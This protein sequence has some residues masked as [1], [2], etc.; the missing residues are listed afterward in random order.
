MSDL[1]AVLAAAEPAEPRTLD[2]LVDRLT[3]RRLV[4]GA[5]AADRRAIDPRGLGGLSIRGISQDSRTVPRDGLFVAIPGAHVDG[6]DRAGEAADRGALCAVVEHALDLDLPQLVVD[7]SRRALAEAAAWWYAD[8]SRELVVVG[9]T[10]TDGKTTTSFL[11]AAVLEAAG[12]RPGLVGTV[13]IGVG[14]QRWPN[15][16]HVTTP[17]APELQRMLRAM[18]SAGDRSAVVESTS[19]GLAL[20]RLD[21]VAYDAAILTNVT[22]EHLELHGTWE[23]YRDAKLSLFERLAPGA[24]NP[25]KDAPKVAIVNAD[26]PSAG[27]FAGVAQ[28][29]GARVVTYGTD[30]QADVR[31]TRVEEDRSGLA[32]DYRSPAGGG[33]VRVR[34]AGRFNA[35]N[36]LAV[37][38]LGEAWGLDAEA[39]RS[40]IESVT[41]VPG[42][43]ERID[44]G[45]PFQVVVDYAHSPAS[46]A[47]V[48]DLLA[49]L[50]A[51]QGGGLV[52][53]FG[54]AGERDVDKRSAM[55]RIAGERC[56]LVVVTDED[57]RGEDREAILEAIAAGAESAGLRRDR[58]LLLIAD[59][60]AAVRAAFERARP[61]DIV[62]LAGKGHET[63][64]IGPRGP[65]PWDER[66]VA[67]E[68]LAVLGHERAVGAGS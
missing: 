31:V 42:R 9:I 26:D 3:S 4:R 11:A 63:T 55:G 19:H 54:S 10:G 20:R 67:L 21:A 65:E 50:A 2:S 8:P 43:M 51:A 44:A 56:R 45:Q 37:V 29:A 66:S 16:G 27:L 22:H 68:E 32:V 15:A 35:H 40:G 18:V 47:L 52:A 12:L 58:E 5:R 13:A 57:P 64:I 60:R 1:E 17:E 36:A 30:R 34:L 25:A 59:R 46:L 53:V 48:L 6:H 62:L 33:M 49:P 39:V 61:G 14:G 24:A 7:S 38:A 41:S 28:E 23:A